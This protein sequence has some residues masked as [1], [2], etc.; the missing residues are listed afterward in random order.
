MKPHIRLEFAFAARQD[1]DDILQY[2]LDEW[3]GPSATAQ[4]RRHGR[5]YASQIGQ[6]KV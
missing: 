5:I 6:G 1:I 3:D 2:T 4:L